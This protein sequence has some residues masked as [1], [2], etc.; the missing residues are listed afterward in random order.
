MDRLHKILAHAGVAS[1]R[2]AEK[3]IE[4]GRVSV[5]GVVIREMG[6][7]ADPG[8]DR[9]TVDGKPLRRPAQ[10]VYL[11]LNKPV[12]VLS[13]LYD[14]EGRPTVVDLLEK[15]I[16]GK[17][18][19]VGRLDFASEGLLILTN[20]GEL[21]RFM[22]RAGVAAKTY[23]VKVH[24]IPAEASVSRLRRGIRLDN[25]PAAPCEVKLLR[26]VSNSWYEVTLHQGRNRQIR[27]MFEAIGHPVLK[28][29]RTRIGFLEDAKLKAG[30]WRYLTEDEVARFYRLYGEKSQ[31]AKSTK[32][33]AP[34]G[35][36]TV[37]RVP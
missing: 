2:R 14:P 3:M 31:T 5:N 15:R 19:P 13:T 18:Y 8:I 20:D 6:V 37:K 16:R 12:N 4:E 25:S 26:T 28:L 34:A 32:R 30:R 36:L 27:R 7:R 9:I 24:G 22:T 10:P 35:R 17:V 11:L 23:H 29:R 1:R 21:T 33:S